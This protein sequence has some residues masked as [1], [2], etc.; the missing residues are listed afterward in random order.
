MGKRQTGANQKWRAKS[1]EALNIQVVKG[2]RELLTEYARLKGLSVREYV[3][4][5]IEMDCGIDMR[6][7]EHKKEQ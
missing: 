4:G 2:S 7:L 1:Y 5:L 6:T 3:L